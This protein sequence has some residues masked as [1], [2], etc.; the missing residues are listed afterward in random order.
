M[1]LAGDDDAD[2]A[3]TSRFALG[4]RLRRL[5]S[6][7]VFFLALCLSVVGV[8][9]GGAIPIV[10]ILGRFLGIALAG[11]VLAFLA[12]GR[13]YAEAAAGGAV[14]AGFGFVLGSLGAVT[15]PVVADYGVQIAGVGITTGLVAALV[16]HYLGRDLRDGLTRDL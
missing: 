3:S 13:R 5:F 9:A 14:A 2:G 11:F 16:G 15:L 4:P 1:R 8:V 12:S 7:R 10:G 6:P